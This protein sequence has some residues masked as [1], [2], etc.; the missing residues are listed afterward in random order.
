V[1]DRPGITTYRLAVDRTADGRS[2]AVLTGRLERACG[3][4]LLDD[5]LR[6][7]AE[8]DRALVLVLDQVQVTAGSPLSGL[9]ALWTR[10]STWPGIPLVL[11]AGDPQMRS[12]LATRAVSKFVP[13]VASQDQAT[14]LV[15]SSAPSRRNQIALAC[16]RFSPRRARSWLRDQLAEWGVQDPAPAELVSTELV[17]NAIIHARSASVLRLDL[18]PDTLSV[19]VLDDDASPPRLIPLG[20]RVNGGR[21]LVIVD[22]LARVWGTSPRAGPGKV[23]W[24]VLPRPQ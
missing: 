21:G 20:E 14:A 19:A 7:A 13:T 6:V 18:R 3:A 12:E 24:A 10:V 17:D 15:S 2:V 11:V 8:A 16:N 23:V 1:P 4:A 5:L 22:R 9:V